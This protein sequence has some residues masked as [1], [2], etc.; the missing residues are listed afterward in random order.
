MSEPNPYEPPRETEPL[1]TGKAVK[2]SVGLIAVLVLTPAAIFA[3]FFVSCAVA[4]TATGAA[5]DEPEPP[6]FWAITLAPTSL[7]A[8]G[9]LVW[10]IRAILRR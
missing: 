9:M 5:I 10:A 3:T 4:W 6:L 8:A 2:R 1:T 7:V